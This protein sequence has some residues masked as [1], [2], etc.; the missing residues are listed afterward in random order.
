MRK[1]LLAVISALLISAACIFSYAITDPHANL[2]LMGIGIDAGSG[3]IRYTKDFYI[4]VLYTEG[5]DEFSGTKYVTILRGE[6]YTNVD[7]I[8]GAGPE[9]VERLSMEKALEYLELKNLDLS[10]HDAVWQRQR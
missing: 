5:N 8:R 1:K 9:N 4:V 3:F 6:N 10:R 2:Y 7:L